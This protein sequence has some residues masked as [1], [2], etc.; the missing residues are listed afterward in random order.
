MNLL[1]R[2]ATKLRSPRRRA[3]A[4]VK[5]REWSNQMRKMMTFMFGVLIGTIVAT[6]YANYSKYPAVDSPEAPAAASMAPF[7]LMRNA[8]GLTVE[9]HDAF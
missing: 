8:R 2:D 5:S 6:A 1:Q 7:E 3:S 9:Q 4:V